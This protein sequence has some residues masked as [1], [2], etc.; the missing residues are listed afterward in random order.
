MAQFANE[1]RFQFWLIQIRMGLLNKRMENLV[2]ASL[3]RDTKNTRKRALLPFR[4]VKAM[5]HKG[6]RIAGE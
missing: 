2:L 3:L 4:I 1:G 6:K 5:I